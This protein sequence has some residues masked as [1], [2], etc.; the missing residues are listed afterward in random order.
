M[1]LKEDNRYDYGVEM[2]QFSGDN[3]LIE[4][5][6]CCVY[7]IHTHLMRVRGEVMRLKDKAKFD[8]YQNF[9]FFDIE[10]IKKRVSDWFDRE[11]SGFKFDVDSTVFRNVNPV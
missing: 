7:D 1:K 10:E 2:H 9:D 11:S 4:L 5:F 3:G 8:F 6:F